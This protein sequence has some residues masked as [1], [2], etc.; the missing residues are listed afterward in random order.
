MSANK[1][2]KIG[3]I[4][5]GGV[6]SI[7]HT[8]STF[9]ANKVDILASTGGVLLN[10]KDE[11]KEYVDSH[12][13][14]FI[15]PILYYAGAEDLYEKVHF[16]EQKRIAEECAITYVCVE[17]AFGKKTGWIPAW[18]KNFRKNLY[19]YNYD[20]I[21]GIAEK[22][23]GA[24]GQCVVVT[25]PCLNIARL[26]QEKSGM[27]PGQVV[28]FN[29][30]HE[31]LILL[32]K[33]IAFDIPELKAHID[34]VVLA[35]DHGSISQ[36]FATPG[37]Y[38][39]CKKHVKLDEIISAVMSEGLD[40]VLT[41]GNV[42]D[43]IV[44]QMGRHIKS[45]ISQDGARFVS[46]I[47]H[48][49]IFCSL[50]FSN[51]MVGDE[52]GM[53]IY[54]AIPDDWVKSVEKSPE[55]RG[56]YSRL[57]E[58][59]DRMKTREP[60]EEGVVIASFPGSA[61]LEIQGYNLPIK[62]VF[63]E[64]GEV[65]LFKANGTSVAKIGS[66][67][68]RKRIV[69]QLCYWNSLTDLPVVCELPRESTS[70]SLAIDGK[71]CYVGSVCGNKGNISIYDFDLSHEVKDNRCQKSRDFDF[72]PVALKEAPDCIYCAD[73]AGNIRKISKAGLE[74]KVLIPG[75]GKEMSQVNEL[76]FANAGNSSVLCAKTMPN[77]DKNSPEYGQSAVY[78]W[79]CSRAPRQ[80]GR[81][82]VSENCF[83]IA[84]DD[85]RIAYF[86]ATGSQ[87]KAGFIGGDVRSANLDFEIK[88][89]K[90]DPTGNC[91][92]ACGE[93]NVM[94]CPFDSRSGRFIEKQFKPSPFAS[95]SS[96]HELQV[97]KYVHKI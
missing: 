87:L 35:G 71:L 63:C 68:K 15:F 58:D 32:L 50:P 47:Y 46:G 40:M 29:P 64:D 53:P 6:G 20:V 38:S 78:L 51:Q 90:F 22:F 67:S 92:Y 42:G 23:K 11:K 34:D 52:N 72:S 77:E 27:E 13:R 31:R 97:G 9:L 93:T 41:H 88:H 65:K 74:D 7:G 17:T 48:N 55:F 86:L 5:I 25:N 26:F 49:G 39:L 80:I 28:A 4:G 21:C 82:L 12:A 10:N 81:V 59:Q 76:L 89:I 8:L 44:P 56:L 95:K 91:V 24:K 61:E 62:K 36:L 1:L 54:R 37:F 85:H 2:P 73:N 70:L 43:N 60:A 66:M 14:S 83:D 45:S 30:D 84:P 79:D 75:A 69:K 16:G 33:Q 57:G 96:V 94:I 19:A 18:Q 3:V